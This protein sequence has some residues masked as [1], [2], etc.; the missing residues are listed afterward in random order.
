MAVGYLL[1]KSTKYGIAVLGG[2]AGASLTM[3]VCSLFIHNMALFWI[4][5]IVVGIGCTALSYK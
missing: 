5:I 3:L 4:L 1:V 2:L